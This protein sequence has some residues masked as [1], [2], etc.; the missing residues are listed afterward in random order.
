[1]VWVCLGWM[2]E[3]DRVATNGVEGIDVVCGVITLNVRPPRS[4]LERAGASSDFGPSPE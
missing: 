2:A 1:M 3:L 4:C